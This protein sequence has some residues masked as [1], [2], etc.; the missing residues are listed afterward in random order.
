MLDNGRWLIAWGDTRKRQANAKETISV[1][2]VD[3]STGTVHLHVNMS[4]GTQEADTYRVYREREAD[5]SIPL[6]LP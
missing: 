5:V 1:T 3:P 6:N 2:E 4:K